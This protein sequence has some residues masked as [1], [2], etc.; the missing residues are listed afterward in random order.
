MSGLSVCEFAMIFVI[1]Y[2]AKLELQK[3][4]NSKNPAAED[5]ACSEDHADTYTTNNEGHIQVQAIS[6]K[7]VVLGPR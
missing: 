3:E 6:E 2:F 5:C 4:A 1:R 7:G